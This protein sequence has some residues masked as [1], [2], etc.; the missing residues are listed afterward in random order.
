MYIYW[1]AMILMIGA[2]GLY[3]HMQNNDEAAFEEAT[4]DT[5]SRS[6][7]I[8]R[9][10][11]AEYARANPGFT[12]TPAE[13]SLH[14]PD[15]Y[16]KQAGITSYVIGGIS[17]TYISGEIPSGLASALAERTES[18]LVGV[19]RSGQLFSPKAGNVAISIPAPIPEGAV[20]A[21][22]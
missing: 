6:L 13:G 18:A 7:L 22:Y 17:Y 20:V 2:T 1:I 10:A 12:G 5:L 9:S 11:T 3:S 16:T 14:F 21:V 19:K 15:W 8:Y 4:V